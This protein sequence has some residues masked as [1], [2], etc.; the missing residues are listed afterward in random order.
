MLKKLLALYK[1]APF[2]APLPEEKVDSTYR[3]LRIQMMVTIFAGYAILI[4]SIAS[5]LLLALTWR[6]HDRR[7]H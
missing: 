2:I 3:R 4:A 1:P 5:M 7:V 6:A